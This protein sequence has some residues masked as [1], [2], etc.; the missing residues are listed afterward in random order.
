MKEGAQVTARLRPTAHGYLTSAVVLR[1]SCCRGE[2]SERQFAR[3][4][5]SRIEVSGIVAR[6]PRSRHRRCSVSAARNHSRTGHRQNPATSGTAAGQAKLKFHLL[7]IAVLSVVFVVI[8][9]AIFRIVFADLIH[10]NFVKH[11]THHVFGN[12]RSPAERVFDDVG[13][14]ATPFDDK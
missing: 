11:N 5:P 3:H 1:R 9:T 12:P 10:I 14:C 13:F 4:P 7:R 2:R 6:H 8:I